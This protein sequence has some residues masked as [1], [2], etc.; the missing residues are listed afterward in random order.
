MEIVQIVERFYQL[1]RASSGMGAAESTGSTATRASLVITNQ[2][3]KRC[4]DMTSTVST[5]P[6]GAESVRPAVVKIIHVVGI[7]VRYERDN[8][9]TFR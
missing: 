5:L 6:M 2:L 7:D 1:V 4:P 3:D 9:F 8:L